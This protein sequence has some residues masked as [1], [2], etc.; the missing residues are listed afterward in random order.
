MRDYAKLIGSLL[1]KAESTIHEAEAASYRAKA[2]ELMREYRVSEEEA[3]A[4]DPGSVMPVSKVMLIRTGSSPESEMS[5]RIYD[6]FSLIAN[7][8]GVRHFMSRTED[9][10]IQA[11][12]VG[13]E[14]DV[15]Y[16]EFLW[17][18]A[19]LMFSTRI[20]PSWSADRSEEENIFLM[21]QSGIERR[22]IADAAWGNGNDAAARSKVQRIYLRECARRGEE[23]L[24]SGLGFT[25]STYRESYADSF[26][27]TLHRRLREARDA[28]NSTAGLPVHHGRQERVDEAFYTMFPR[29]RPDTS[30]VVAWV[31]PR[32]ECAKCK[33]AKSGACNDHSYMRPRAWTQADER[34]AWTRTN[35]A[36]AV[37]GRGAGRSAAEGVNVT[38]GHS[39]E[40][41]LDRANGALEG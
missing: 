10:G 32:T 1:A 16:V 13:Y 14:G 41:R 29:L 24:A 21:R 15:R 22:R 12:V 36:S 6:I 40:N 25:T 23:P 5:G 4:V 20:D 27:T 17:T 30:P 26:V 38:R 18:A 35:G 34:R 39:T 31:D 8:C 33:K 3:L 7:H 28:A 37:A 19:Y 9:Y 2:E 11:T